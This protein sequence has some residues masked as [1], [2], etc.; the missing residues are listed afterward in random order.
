[1]FTYGVPD[2]EPFVPPQSI[3]GFNLPLYILELLLPYSLLI[4]LNAF[5]DAYC[6]DPSVKFFEP[7]PV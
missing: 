2:T 3:F 1:M 5:G 6:I 7:N 4:P